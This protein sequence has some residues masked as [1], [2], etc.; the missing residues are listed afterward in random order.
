MQ[1][2]VA[3]ELEDRVRVYVAARRSDGKSYPAFVDVAVDD[4]TAVLGVNE[5]PIMPL[6]ALGTFDDDGIMPAC[7]LNVQ[8]ELWLYYSGWNRRVSVPYHNTTGLAKST[9]GGKT[10][11]K[12]FDGPILERTPTE[13]FMAVTPWVLRS[14]PLWKMWYV[15]GLGWIDVAGRLEPVY[16]IKYGESIDGISWTRPGNLVISQRHVAEA[17]ARPCVIERDGQYHMWYCYRNSI[18]FRDGKGS[19][20]I[21]YSFSEDGRIWRR[22]DHLAGIDLSTDGWDSTM[23]C[24]PYILQINGQLYLFYNGNSFG[25]TGVGCAVWQGQLPKP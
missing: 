14:G 21:G 13:P 19:Y 23:Q 18:D 11:T 9:D 15:S 12:L 8:Q 5:E 24:Y 1:G 10:F 2:P 4:P 3:V 20:R 17:I 6:G 25:Q 7:A 16:G 22:A